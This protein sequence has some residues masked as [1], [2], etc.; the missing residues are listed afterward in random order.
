MI[1][2]MVLPGKE[3]ADALI[4]SLARTHKRN[5]SFFV[6]IMVGNDERMN[7]FVNK[8]AKT[9]EIIGIDFHAV[10][11]DESIS[12]HE[13]YNEVEYYASLRQCTG[14]IVQLPL[15]KHI[16]TEK[17]LRIIPKEK[18][19]DMLGEEAQE[20]FE[21]DKHIIVPP[22]VRTLMHFSSFLFPELSLS[23]MFKTKTCVILGHGGLVGKPIATWLRSRAKRVIV[24]D[25]GFDE[26]MLKH[27]D[28]II[29]GTGVPHLF[30]SSL[31]KND[32]IVID[33]GYGMLI[34]KL[35][36]DFNPTDV[37]DSIVH[38]KTPGGTG[39]VLVASLF[40]NYETLLKEFF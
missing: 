35:A 9:A 30:N 32:A 20:L 3:I 23:E 31:L 19:P 7:S 37:P 27:A 14:I 38:T 40:E 25:K 24:L 33:F 34:E 39:P 2:T 21:K 12:T 36:G 1:H 29:S 15:P 26:E 8:K 4:S 13:L 17:I 11:F 6:A 22:P 28:V 16:D 10:R 18:D 5:E